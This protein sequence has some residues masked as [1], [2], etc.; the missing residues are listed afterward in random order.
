MPYAI[1]VTIKGRRVFAGN[2]GIPAKYAS[3][4]EAK[5]DVVKYLTGKG[6][7]PLV[8]NYP[9]VLNF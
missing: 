5:K 9:A 1:K 8:C 3:K 2:S 4:S 7:R 6:M